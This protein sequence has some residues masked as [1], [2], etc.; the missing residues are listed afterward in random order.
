MAD[1]VLDV[2]AGAGINLAE[3]GGTLTISST[4]A[5][6]VYYGDGEEGYS[7]IAN[8]TYGGTFNGPATDAYYILVHKRYGTQTSSPVTTNKIQY[9][10]YV[11]YMVTERVNAT[12]ATTEYEVIYVL[13]M[14]TFVVYL[15]GTGTTKNADGSIN[16]TSWVFEDTRTPE[17]A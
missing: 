17:Q 7:T 13:D 10:Q 16:I 2:V 14:G 4:A 3:S 8:P 9:D 6:V 1:Q 11:K 15:K 5:S 12:T